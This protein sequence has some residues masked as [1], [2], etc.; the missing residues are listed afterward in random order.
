MRPGTGVLIGLLV[1]AVVAFCNAT[2][3]AQ[4]AAVHPESGGTYVYAR[5]QL[6]P[7]WG[8][9]AGWGFVIGKTASCVAIALTAG[10]Y[11]WPEHARLVGVGAV[12]AVAIVNLGGLTRTVLVTKAL[13]ADRAGHSRLG[14]HRRLVDA[15]DI[16]GAAHAHR[17]VASRGV[18][19]RGVPLLRVRRLRPH[20]HPRRGG[21]RPGD[22]DPQGDP[23]C[24]RRSVGGLRGRRR[25]RARH[26]ARR[27]HRRQRRTARAGCRHLAIRLA[28][29]HRSYRRRDRRARRAA[30]PH[31]RRLADGARHGTPP[32]APALVGDDRRPP[33]APPAGRDH[34]HRRG[35]R[36]HRN[37]RP[38]RCHRLL[39]SHHPHVLRDHQRRLPDPARRSAPMATPDRRR[40]S[41]RL[42]RPRSDARWTIPAARE[43]R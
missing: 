21:P 35:H 42:P 17:H 27:R 14:R 7:M 34:R 9:L 1:A 2:S 40:R 32:R 19:R 36:P 23:A 4:L 26:A 37:T 30:Q 3:S 43:S 22:H 28:R 15:H 39:R 18:T 8:Y 41:R 29:P 12:A 31:P 16:A 25:H 5:R 33:L 20:R 38:S 6:S 13:L 11:L 24:P 10:A